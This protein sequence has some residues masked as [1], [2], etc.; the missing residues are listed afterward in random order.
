MLVQVWTVGSS[1]RSGEG[2]SLEEKIV[3]MGL[4]SLRDSVDGLEGA[5]VIGWSD[6]D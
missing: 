3:G 1:R 4:G 6:G 2:S 5:C